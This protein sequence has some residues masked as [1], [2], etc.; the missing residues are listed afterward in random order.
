[1][2][3][4]IETRRVHLIRYLRFINTS[5]EEVL[6]SFHLDKLV[7]ESNHVLPIYTYIYLTLK[8]PTVKY[9]LL[10]RNNFLYKHLNFILIH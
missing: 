1:M 2:K 6:K 8:D 9:G 3:V 4:T 5:Y 7:L 10:I